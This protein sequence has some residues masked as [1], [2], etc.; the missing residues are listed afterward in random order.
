M[1]FEDDYYGKFETCVVCGYVHEDAP[2]DSKVLVE[3]MRLVA[4]KPRRRRPS[5]SFRSL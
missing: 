3:E 1:I 4:G 2:V 5:H